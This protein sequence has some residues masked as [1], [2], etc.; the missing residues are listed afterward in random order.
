MPHWLEKVIVIVSSD[1]LDLRTLAIS[2]GGDPRDFYIGADMS[3][4]DLRGQNLLGMAFT[5]F[6]P[7]M[8]QI[9]D[10]TQLDPEYSA[11]LSNHDE[12]DLN[13]GAGEE[14]ERQ[15]ILSRV[16][17]IRLMPRQESRVAALLRGILLNR[18]L[19]MA[20]LS[21]YDGDRAEFAKKV[22]GFTHSHISH[23]PTLPT[24]LLISRAVEFAISYIYGMRK[25]VLLLALAEQLGEF[26]SLNALIRNRTISTNSI[27]AAPYVNDILSTLDRHGNRENVLPTA[28][29]S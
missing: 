25:G 6:D 22:L 19:G 11:P 2:A 21:T 15:E 26:P 17:Q 13:Q 16:T 27:F 28:L 24:A 18:D 7:K 1:S 29:T 14:R 3:G 5:N 12:L 20:V 9:D 4:A 8:V 10:N 23:N